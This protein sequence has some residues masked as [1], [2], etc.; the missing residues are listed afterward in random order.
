[1]KITN[2]K[3]LPTAIVKA[4]SNEYHR[5]GDYS[6]TDLQKSAK[7]LWLTK[8][9][10]PEI[11]IDASD[12]L[13]PLF[14]SAIHYVLE[15]SDDQNAFQEEFLK[16]EFAGKYL[17]GRPDHFDGKIITDYKFTSV[18]SLVYQSSFQEWEKQ[19]NIYALLYSLQG[20]DVEK[21]QI[22]A[23]LKDWSKNKYKH[24]NNYPDSQAQ[25]IPFKPSFVS[26][27]IA[28]TAFILPIKESSFC[29][30]VDLIARVFLE[31]LSS[32][33]LICWLFLIEFKLCFKTPGILFT[34]SMPDRST[35]LPAGR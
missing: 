29:L 22:I 35:T 5:E 27:L 32:S 30:F 28:K 12:R 21:V 19:L 3:N 17:T 26:T 10:E 34:S 6:A 25:I 1:M 15:K 16:A 14:G 23:L 2:K 20:F 8:R 11:E 13:W 9:H 7:Q 24:D 4:V 31:A 18:W 33:D